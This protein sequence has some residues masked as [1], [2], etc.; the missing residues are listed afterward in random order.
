MSFRSNNYFIRRFHVY[1]ANRVQQIR[2]KSDPKSWRYVDTSCNPADEVSRGLTA[3]QLIE[4]SCWLTGP[5]FLQKDGP[6]VTSEAVAL[7]LDE[8]DPEVKR[9]AVLSTCTEATNKKPV[10]RSL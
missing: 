6:T 1:V 10:P 4:K 2:D 5:E 7:K 3:K 9:A 8:A